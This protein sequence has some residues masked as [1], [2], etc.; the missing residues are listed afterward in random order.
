M[1]RNEKKPETSVTVVSTIVELVAGSWP[2]RLIMIGMN[3]P[4]MPAIVI[5]AT[6]ARPITSASP[7]DLLQT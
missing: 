7:G 1:P 6:I 3:A 2:R 5:D 4:A